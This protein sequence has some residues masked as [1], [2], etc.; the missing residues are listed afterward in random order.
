MRRVAL[1]CEALKRGGLR[2]DAER[3][4]GRL[5]LFRYELVDFLCGSYINYIYIL[6]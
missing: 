2:V 6:R 3:N 1:P 5:E 4:S